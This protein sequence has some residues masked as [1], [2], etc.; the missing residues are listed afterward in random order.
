MDCFHCFWGTNGQITWNR[1][2]KLGK[3][4]QKLLKG[5][6]Q[7]TPFSD[8]RTPQV[9]LR[10]VPYPNVLR[11]GAHELRLTRKKTIARRSPPIKL[12]KKSRAKFSTARAK[13]PS[14]RATVAR[15]SEFFRVAHR[16]LS[17]AK[18][19]KW[20]CRSGRRLPQVSVS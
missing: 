12:H 7:R 3:Y 8:L 20:R 17:A 11:A 5:G 1:G 13:S 10:D 4:V 2:R 18:A 16:R 14:T 19:H 6:D 15:N 9:Q